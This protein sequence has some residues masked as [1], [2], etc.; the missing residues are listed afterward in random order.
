MTVADEIAK[1]LRDLVLD[2]DGNVR[3]DAIKE[4]YFTRVNPDGIRWYPSGVWANEAREKVWD[5]LYREGILSTKMAGNFLVM[6]CNVVLN[7]RI[8]GPLFFAREKDAKAYVDLEYAGAL[9]EINIIK[10]QVTS[11]R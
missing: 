3:W 7:P 10:C 5:L 2:K 11:P 6:G 9:Y 4:R 1:E 8:V